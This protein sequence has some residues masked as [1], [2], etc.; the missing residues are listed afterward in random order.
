MI[1]ILTKE[2]NPQKCLQTS[3]Y[4]WLMVATMKENQ[5]EDIFQMKR[6][7]GKS[8]GL[9]KSHKLWLAIEKYCLFN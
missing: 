7:T 9:Q 8:S 6:E 4:P 5:V 2:K 1:T 3:K